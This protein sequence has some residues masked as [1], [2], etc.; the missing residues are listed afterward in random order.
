M[1]ASRGVVRLGVGELGV[2]PEVAELVRD[3][4]SIYFGEMR[5]ISIVLFTS[6]IVCIGRHS[7]GL[8]VLSLLR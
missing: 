8:G 5:T 6:C 3:G 4:I 2:F 1:N 7:C